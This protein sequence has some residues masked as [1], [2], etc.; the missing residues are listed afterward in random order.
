MLHAAEGPAQIVVGTLEMLRDVADALLRGRR[1]EVV[2]R[3]GNRVECLHEPIAVTVSD[4]LVRDAHADRRFRLRCHGGGCENAHCSDETSK[5]M[6]YQGI[7]YSGYT[8]AIDRYGFRP[9]LPT[10]GLA[11]RPL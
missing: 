1:P 5:Q 9:P 8:A 11:R 3:G 10:Q 7:G 2:A 6:H 4:V